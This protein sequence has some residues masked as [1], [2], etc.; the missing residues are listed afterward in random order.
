MEKFIVG[1]FM[2]IIGMGYFAIGKK[3][4]N[5]VFLISG[6]LMMVIPYFVSNWLSLSAIFLL[7]LIAPFFF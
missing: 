5:F 6:I 3:R 2:G 4:A 7:T 1:F